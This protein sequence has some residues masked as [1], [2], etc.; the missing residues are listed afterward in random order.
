M[1][2]IEISVLAD[3]D[4]HVFVNKL[5]IWRASFDFVVSRC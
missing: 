3:L 1:F 5:L 2:Y 4:V